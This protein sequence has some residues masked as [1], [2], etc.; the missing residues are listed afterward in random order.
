MSRNSSRSASVISLCKSTL[1]RWRTRIPSRVV[2]TAP[3]RSLVMSSPCRAGWPSSRPSYSQ[4]FFSWLPPREAARAQFHQAPL[5][6]ITA[7]RGDNLAQPVAEVVF[8]ELGHARDPA[9][10]GG[11]AVVIDGGGV[12]FVFAAK[13]G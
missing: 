7:E 5:D 10:H 13:R 6:N 4:A 12:D 11:E 3:A 9:P 8:V 1:R 2:A